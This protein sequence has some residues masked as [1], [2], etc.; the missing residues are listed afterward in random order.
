ME[1]NRSSQ[2]VNTNSPIRD[3]VDEGVD[4]SFPASDPPAYT[5]TTGVSRAQPR[6]DAAGPTAS[7]EA[8]A[9]HVVMIGA[10]LGGLAAA[11]GLEGAGRARHHPGRT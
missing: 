3:L 7:A 6:R 8:K 10:G 11:K 1:N 4:E 9:P 5:A 2:G